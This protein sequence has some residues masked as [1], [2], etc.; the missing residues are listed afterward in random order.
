M[1]QTNPTTSTSSVPVG[2]ALPAKQGKIP[3][4]YAIIGSESQVAAT[5]S[6]SNLNLCRRICRAAK[7]S[8]GCRAL[9]VPLPP[10]RN[11]REA[12]HYLTRG[13][14]ALAFVSGRLGRWLTPT[15]VIVP[16]TRLEVAE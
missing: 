15:F 8:N 12:E 5:E 6:H 13:N 1:T 11:R 9:V 4:R 14:T 10:I 7:F 3:G 2:N 16:V